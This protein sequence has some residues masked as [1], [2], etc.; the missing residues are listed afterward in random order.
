M[1]LQFFFWSLSLWRPVSA[2]SIPRYDA[3][4]PMLSQPT[5]AD[6]TSY[7]LKLVMRNRDSFKFLKTGYST[8]V[9]KTLSFRCKFSCSIQTQT[10]SNASLR[11]VMQRCHHSYRP[12]RIL[13]RRLYLCPSL[14][15]WS[16]PH[17]RLLLLV[18]SRRACC[19]S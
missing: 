3:Q 14:Y 1:T 9:T 17:L 13:Q 11:S 4:S 19:Q 12:F 18:V 16:L 7:Q 8:G 6:D 10:P 15:P 5:N 2:L